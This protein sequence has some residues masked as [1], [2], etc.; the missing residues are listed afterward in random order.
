[1]LLDVILG[2]VV[3]LFHQVVVDEHGARDLIFSILGFLAICQVFDRVSDV[4]SRLVFLALIASLR[5]VLGLLIGQILLKNLALVLFHVPP[6]NIIF[7]GLLV[8]KQIARPIT[9]LLHVLVHQHVLLL[10]LLHV[11]LDIVFMVMVLTMASDLSVALNIMLAV[12][13]RLMV[14]HAVGVICLS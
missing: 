1:M 5:P 14:K 7:E 9:H 8:G 13:A 6:L 12:G 3:Y 11:G 4:L 2:V 10:G